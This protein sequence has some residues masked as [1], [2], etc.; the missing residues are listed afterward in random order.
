M[1]SIA[2]IGAGVASISAIDALRDGGYDGPI[3]LLSDEQQLPY[4]RPPLSKDVL[5]GSA[6]DGVALRPEAFYR[7]NEVDLLLGQRVTGLDCTEMAFTTTDGT[8]H[9][10]RSIVLATGGSARRL[11]LPGAD[12]DG[13]FVLR[14]L[15]DAIALR[16][17]F[18][19]GARLAVIGGG[20]I[21]TEVAASAVSS[22]LDV[23]LLE[24]AAMPLAAVL[25]ELA[26]RVVDHHR[27]RGVTIR[28]E[29]AVEAFT[30]Q[31]QV[32]GV[33]LADGE[34]VPAD[35]VVVGIGMRPND[36]LAAAAGLATGNGV[37]VDESMRTAAPGV[38]AIGDVANIGTTA[39]RQRCEHWSHAVDTGR[40]LAD[41]LLGRSGRLR[42]V[43]WFWSDQ[44]D[45]NIQLVGRPQPADERVWREDPIRD[46]VT[47]LFHRQGRLTGAV[48]L[49]NGRD[50]RPITD[51]IAAG[52]ALDVRDLDEPRTDLRKLAKQMRSGE[53]AAT[54]SIS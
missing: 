53:S 40:R 18:T 14:T 1:N 36:G 43:P 50:I 47:V 38:Y 48:T 5:Q 35:L 22:G 30:G 31:D 12:L 10:A 2:F 19:A 9:R 6:P 26:P 29:V 11:P 24:A 46:R 52:A 37:H 49:N 33:R 3:S 13:V 41:D 32:T 25:P 20:F 17:R 42:P 16:R 27:Q 15:D 51:L 28:T 45:L 54:A 21:G 23:V 8:Q 7:D 44:Y 4:D 39:G 34:V